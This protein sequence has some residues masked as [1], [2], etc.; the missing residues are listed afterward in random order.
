[1]SHAEG[2]RDG[3]AFSVQ[4]YTSYTGSLLDCWQREGYTLS[5]SQE[6][7]SHV[8]Q[9]LMLRCSYVKMMVIYKSSY[10]AARFLIVHKK[11]YWTTIIKKQQ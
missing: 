8:A 4:Q 7:R 9:N 1:M 3:Q 10:H 6:A 2:G 11:K 5:S